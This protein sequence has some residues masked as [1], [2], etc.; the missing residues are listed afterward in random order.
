MAYLREVA[1]AIYPRLPDF[2]VDVSRLEVKILFCAQIEVVEEHLSIGR[3]EDRDVFVI[4]YLVQRLIQ[5]IVFRVELP[6]QLREKP[7]FLQVL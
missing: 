3:R 5:C 1:H 6:K 4:G 2:L 7:G